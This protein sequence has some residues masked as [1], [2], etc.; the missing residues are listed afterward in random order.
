MAG[1]PSIRR[2]RYDC[3]NMDRLPI[4]LVLQL[5]AGDRDVPRR[6][7]LLTAEVTASRGDCSARPWTTVD[8]NDRSGTGSR[9]RWRLADARMCIRGP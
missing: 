3:R 2:R 6:A 9:P 4:A 7:R 1:L 5:A 8:V